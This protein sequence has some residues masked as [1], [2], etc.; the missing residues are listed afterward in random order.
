MELD[1]KEDVSENYSNLLMTLQHY[2]SNRIPENRLKPS[3]EL[4]SFFNIQSILNK[5]RLSLI[6][7]LK[8]LLC[9]SSF[10]S[11]K[12]ENIKIISGLDLSLVQTYYDSV[13]LFLLKNVDKKNLGNIS[14]LEDEKNLQRKEIENLKKIIEEKDLIIRQYKSKDFLRNNND[15]SI[16]PSAQDFLGGGAD[17]LATMVNFD[18]DFDLHNNNNNNNN[19]YNNKNFQ[20]EKTI[21]FYYEKINIKQMFIDSLPI[22]QK[23]TNNSS[24]SC[25]NYSISKHYFNLCGGDFLQRKI[26]ILDETILKNREMYEKIVGDYENEIKNL[27]QKIEEL[28]NMHNEKI[29]QMVKN[30]ENEIKK[31]LNDKKMNGTEELIKFRNEKNIEIAK[32]RK[33][34]DEKELIKNKEI[35]ELKNKINEVNLI[36][37]KDTEFFKLEKIKKK[38]N[39]NK[40]L[41]I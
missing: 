38:M 1:E 28:K 27:K 36:R 10:C 21:N 41:I 33:E 19:N 3:S 34:M 2:I 11:N 40:K 22:S 14:N 29:N 16:I 13:Y 8:L 12:R 6:N 25:H 20:V 7:L 23:N 31:V 24:N 4:L 15:L 30:H 37:Q 17:D 35:E 18:L 9:V 5:D 26:E 32:I 39:M